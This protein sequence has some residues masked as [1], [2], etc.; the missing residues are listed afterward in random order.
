MYN[1]LSSM[2]ILYMNVCCFSACARVTCMFLCDS[3]V[4]IGEGGFGSSSI[5][6]L[7]LHNVL[8]L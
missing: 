8:C 7:F 3:L 6:V 2:R 1:S 4:G 5:I